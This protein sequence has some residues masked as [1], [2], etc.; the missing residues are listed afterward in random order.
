MD[1]TVCL[2]KQPVTITDLASYMLGRPA[3]SGAD[4]AEAGLPMLGGCESC[5]ATIAAY[6]AYPSTTGYLRCADDVA[7]AE[8]FSV[9]EAYRLIF[10]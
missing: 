9:R 7:G 4:Y 10:D 2:T 5:E 8:F 3:K 1:D 6:N